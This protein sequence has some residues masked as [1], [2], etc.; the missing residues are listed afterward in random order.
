M[1]T[2]RIL[3]EDKVF[4]VKGDYMLSQGGNVTIYLSEDRDE[5]DECMVAFFH[6]PIAAYEKTED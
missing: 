4:E 3:T 6:K 5:T 1:R 2:Y